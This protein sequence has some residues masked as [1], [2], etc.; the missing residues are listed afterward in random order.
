MLAPSKTIPIKVIQI[1]C[2]SPVFGCLLA[3]AV[4]LIF[5]LVLLVGIV[6]LEL[7]LDEPDAV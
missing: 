6:L 7:E 4:L 3:L 2:F 5:A 1:D